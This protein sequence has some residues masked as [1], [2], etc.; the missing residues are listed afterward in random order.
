M[1]SDYSMEQFSQTLD[2]VNGLWKLTVRVKIA[3]ARI[4]TL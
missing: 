3:P 2:K 4:V 1:G